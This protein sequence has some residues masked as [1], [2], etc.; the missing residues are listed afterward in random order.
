MSSTDLSVRRWLVAMSRVSSRVQSELRTHDGLSERSASNTAGF[1]AQ[2]PTSAAAYCASGCHGSCGAWV[3]MY[4]TKGRESSRSK[5]SR[6]RIAC[7]SASW[8][9]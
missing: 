3:A 1:P 4:R 2:V 8:V 6:M 7:R 5:L 9:V